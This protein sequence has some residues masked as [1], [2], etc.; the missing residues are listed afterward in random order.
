LAL[1]TLFPSA[2]FCQSFDPNTV[3]NP[4]SIHLS[5]LTGKPYQGI[6]IGGQRERLFYEDADLLRRLRKSLAATKQRN[7]VV[8]VPVQKGQTMLTVRYETGS[9]SGYSER[10]VKEVPVDFFDLQEK[11]LD[12]AGPDKQANRESLQKLLLPDDRVKDKGKTVLFE[13]IG[14]F[15][16]VPES[17]GFA[18]DAAVLTSSDLD[19]AM[20]NYEM[21]RNVRLDPKKLTLFLGFPDSQEEYDA[22]FKGEKNG[23]LLNWRKRTAEVRDMQNEFGFKLI[24][25]QDYKEL[26]KEQVLSLLENA[27]GIVWIAAHSHG[28]F[29]RFP[30]AGPIEIDPQDIASLKLAK[31]PFVVIRVCN[32]E[33]NGFAKAFLVAGASSVWVNHGTLKA[34]DANDQVRLFLQNALTSSIMDAVVAAKAQ[35]QAAKYGTVLHVLDEPRNKPAEQF[36]IEVMIGCCEGPSE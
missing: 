15:G 24:A 26:S 16:F 19:L 32:G 27:E 18:G 7:L 23:E 1:A 35:N 3:E 29:A 14:Y 4:C 5:R 6:A 10:I 12:A 30:G 17:L 22:I 21:L 13:N 33:E 20:K 9:A 25:N 36:R 34:S 2:V 8:Y 28:C 31:H 11:L